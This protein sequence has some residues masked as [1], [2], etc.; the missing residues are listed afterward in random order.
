MQ[1]GRKTTYVSHLFLVGAL[2]AVALAPSAAEGQ[3]PRRSPTPMQQPRVDPLTATIQGRVTTAD[4]GAPVR[5]A[6]VRAIDNAYTRLATTDGDGRYELRDL[7]AGQYR[8]HVS[9]SGFVPLE[10]GQRRP[11]ETPLRVTLKE[12][13]RATANMALPRGAAIAGRVIDEAGEP[14]AGARVQ[15]FRARMIE[16]QRRLLPVGASDVSDD[17]GAF[18][19]HGLPPGEYYVA[20]TPPE[21]RL[22]EVPRGALPGEMPPGANMGRIGTRTAAYYPGTANI[23]EALRIGV[24]VGGEARA[25]MQLGATGAVTVSGLVLTSS[26]APG[27]DAMLSLRSEL[28]S[29]GASAPPSGFMVTGHA[30]PDGTFELRGVPPG[31]YALHVSTGPMNLGTIE[32]PRGL[33][34][35]AS[36]EMA[37]LAVNVGTADVTGLAVTTGPGNAIETTLVA[38]VGVTRPLP[39]G[40]TVDVRGGSAAGVHMVMR[41][42]NA[43]VSRHL[44]SGAVYLQVN[45]LPEDWTVKAMMLDGVDV[46]DR[47]IDSRRG[48]A[49]VRVVLTDR[50]TE[51]T[52]M[53]PLPAAAGDN[54]STHSVVVFPADPAKWT[55]PSRFVRTVRTDAQGTFRLTGLPGDERYLAVAVDY[56]EDGEETDPEFLERIESRASPFTLGDAER[57]T[58]TVPLVQR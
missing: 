40:V 25:D 57:K 31:P 47:A 54:P 6:E 14:M 34:P 2:V 35:I 38:D 46:I 27:A 21:L 10:Y 41:D 51:V 7:P 19:V 12:G 15:A 11:F 3:Q 9:K 28:M 43:D 50:V 36:G 26:G 16:G 33:M 49:S 58:I 45:G 20:A 32:T 42:A 48:T 22:P 39:R 29:M 13:D 23:Q 18:R 1:M 17:T 37:E 4:T 52:G 8:L 24:G 44:T 5:R 30:G 55:Y 56:L 53:V